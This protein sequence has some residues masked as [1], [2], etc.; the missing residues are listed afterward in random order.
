[1]GGTV[2]ADARARMD[3]IWE[4]RRPQVLERVAEVERAAAAVE[5]GME[6]NSRSSRRAAPLRTGSRDRSGCS[7]RPR[8]PRMPPNSRT[9]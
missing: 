1:M 6:T 5:E 9:C 3:A 8:V 2:T 7:D 4:R